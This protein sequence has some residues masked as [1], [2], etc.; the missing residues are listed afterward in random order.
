M[1]K[2]LPAAAREAAVALTEDY[3]EVSSSSLFPGSATPERERAGPAQSL[4]ASPVD[5]W[6]AAPGKPGEIP[7]FLGN[8]HAAKSMPL[9]VELASG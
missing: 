6:G 5:R 2:A 8:S 4:R 9:E 1:K 7:L 3:F